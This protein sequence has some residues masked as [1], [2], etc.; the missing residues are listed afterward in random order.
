MHLEG[1]IKHENLN[2]KTAH[3]ADILVQGWDA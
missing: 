3:I 2:I 1:Y